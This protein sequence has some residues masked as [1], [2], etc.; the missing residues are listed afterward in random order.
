MRH[1]QESAHGR[2]PSMPNCSAARATAAP[3]SATIAASCCVR[4]MQFGATPH[5][6]TAYVHA[7]QPGLH[8]IEQACHRP[9]AGTAGCTHC[10]GSRVRCRGIRQRQ[11]DLV[12]GLVNVLPLVAPALASS[13][14]TTSPSCA[15]RRCRR[16][17]LRLSHGT[18]PARRGV[19]PTSSLSAG[20]PPPISSSTGDAGRA[21]HRRPQRRVAL[22]HA[23][24]SRR[25]AAPRRQNDLPERYLLYSGHAGAAQNLDLLLRAY[26]RWRR[27]VPPPIATWR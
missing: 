6:I 7:R 17:L 8:G 18:L 23:A 16:R 14:C 27:L 12:H 19:P 11:A 13:P 9:S 25:I 22:F 1:W 21:Y 26:A 24:A 20:R 3:A 5:D 4:W 15:R 2:S 10:L